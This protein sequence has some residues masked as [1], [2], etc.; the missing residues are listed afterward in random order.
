MGGR[1]TRSAQAQFPLL[2]QEPHL[3]SVF[4]SEL[5]HFSSSI[6]P[7][8]C[9]SV[10]L[11]VKQGTLLTVPRRVIAKVRVVRAWCVKLG[12]AAGAMAFLGSWCLL[13]AALGHRAPPTGS[14]LCSGG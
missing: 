12:L 3:S 13:W 11:F 1:S 6:T 14:P 9:A 5:G 4:G 2:Q 7:P 8:A 10:S